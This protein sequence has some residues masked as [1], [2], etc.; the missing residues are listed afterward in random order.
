[1]QCTP[2]WPCSS[3]PAPLRHRGRLTPRGTIARSLAVG[4]SSRPTLCATAAADSRRPR[5]WSQLRRGAPGRPSRRRCSVQGSS[6]ARS[7]TESTPASA[8]RCTGTAPSKPG[9]FA[10]TSWCRPCSARSTSPSA[11]STCSWTRGRPRNPG[12]PGP[13][14][15]RRRRCCAF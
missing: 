10:P 8:S 15:G 6:W 12:P 14:G 7:S 3:P 11:C 5:S 2:R 9:P 13:R 1:M 4:L